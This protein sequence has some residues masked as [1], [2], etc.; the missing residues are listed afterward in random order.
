MSSRAPIIYKSLISD[1]R[2]IAEDNSCISYAGTWVKPT[3]RIV[4]FA[5]LHYCFWAFY[6]HMIFCTE[7]WNKCEH[8]C[9]KQLGRQVDW[10]LLHQ[11]TLI[12]THIRTDMCTNLRIHAQ[13]NTSAGGQSQ[14]Q[15]GA[16]RCRQ[17]DRP[18]SSSSG[19]RRRRNASQ[20][21]GKRFFERKRERRRAW[22]L[23]KKEKKSA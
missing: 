16:R 5:T 8:V 23:Q 2:K 20:S 11:C 18:S 7:N 4:T 10:L 6:I 14:L 19:R 13:K 1:R 22:F 15:R 21:S 9:K 17:A 3:W 12:L